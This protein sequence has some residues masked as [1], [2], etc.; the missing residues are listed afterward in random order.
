MA[1]ENTAKEKAETVLHRYLEGDI[2]GK[3]GK[4]KGGNYF[5]TPLDELNL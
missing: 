1:G 2:V 4:F 3:M 5:P